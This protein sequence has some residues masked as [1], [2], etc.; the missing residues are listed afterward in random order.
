MVRKI[1]LIWCY[2]D[3]FFLKNRENVEGQFELQNSGLS[4]V[5]FWASD[6]VLQE[7]APSTRRRH[8]ESSN[9]VSVLR[10][11]VSDNMD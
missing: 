6:T 5:G 4:E 3:G 9:L 8:E 11:R 2:S 10:Q 1:S 7:H